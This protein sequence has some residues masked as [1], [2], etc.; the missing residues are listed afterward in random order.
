MK[1]FIPFNSNDFNNIF[2]TLTISPRCFYAHRGYGYKRSSSV[3]LSPFESFLAGYEVPVMTTSTRNVDGG[4]QVL[5]GVELNADLIA[6]Q[7]TV[8]GIRIYM[9]NRTVYLFDEFELLFSTTKEKEAVLAGTLKSLETKFSEIARA[10]SRVPQEKEWEIVSSDALSLIQEDVHGSLQPSFVWEREANRVAGA[11][12]G[13][14]VGRFT[15]TSQEVRQ[16]QLQSKELNNLVSLYINSLSSGGVSS[17]KRR[18]IDCLVNL[19][20]Q[21]NSIE[22]VE[23]SFVLGSSNLRPQDIERDCAQDYLGVNKFELIIEGLLASDVH[24]LPMP[25]KIEKAIRVVQG[26]YNSKYPDSYAKRLWSVINDIQFGVKR[27]TADS[28]PSAAL[29]L[30]AMPKVTL[31]GGRTSISIPREVGEAHLL[32]LTLRFFISKD[33]LSHPDEFFATR[34]EL[35]IAYGQ[36]L[37]ENVEGWEESDS[38]KYI[39]C[40]LASFKSLKSDFDVISSKS[41][42]MRSL[43]ILFTVGRDLSL[44]L[45]AILTAGI[46]QRGV[47]IAIWG[48]TYGAATM[49]KT[50]TNCIL[51]HNELLKMYLGVLRDTIVSWSG[52][53]CYVAEHGAS[54]EGDKK[55]DVFQVSMFPDDIVTNAK[56]IWTV[57]EFEDALP[58]SKWFGRGSASWEAAR[59]AAELIKYRDSELH[60][61][62]NELLIVKFQD[63]LKERA[64]SVKGLG[65][66][67]IEAAVGVFSEVIGFS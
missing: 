42:V 17:V 40:L 1:L 55:L 53:N 66:K 21:F 12:L 5:L 49:P 25:L 45:D 28:S 50:L 67:K 57:N 58:K 37:R 38:R 60:G 26:K 41:E 43:G 27:S 62:N 23:E 22:S 48:A 32:E 52:D 44:F 10:C 18:L 39:G 56:G 65:P 54:R 64:K 9:I 14:A 61:A 36:F 3:A 47:P 34:Q 35:L 63:A 13:Y 4:V 20:K 51:D 33:G 59:E 2:S 29:S 24:F 30:E 19:K 16:I 46:E 6:V 15:S 11:V 8:G 31:N 7:K